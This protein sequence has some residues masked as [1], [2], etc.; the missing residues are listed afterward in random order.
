MSVRASSQTPHHYYNCKWSFFYIPKRLCSLMNFHSVKSYDLAHNKISSLVLLQ[1]EWAA[2]CWTLLLNKWLREHSKRLLLHR[3]KSS[4]ELKHKHQPIELTRSDSLDI[5]FH[6]SPITNSIGIDM[7]LY[8]RLSANICSISSFSFNTN[9]L[10]RPLHAY[11]SYCYEWNSLK[12]KATKREKMLKLRLT[13]VIKS[14]EWNHD[15]GV[16]ASFRL[17]F[18]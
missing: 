18:S 15:C 14:F 6:C 5:D 17:W 4:A 8:G 13:A 3:S 16:L 10:Q 9:C 1:F 11:R 12:P 7:P 2:V